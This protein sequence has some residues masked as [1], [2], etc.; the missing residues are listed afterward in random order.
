MSRKRN[1]RIHLLYPARE[2]ITQI[3]R[4]DPSKGIPEVIE[5]YRKLCD[6]IINDA[7]EKFPPQLLNCGN[8]AIDDPDAGL[9]FAETTKLLKQS[10]Y[11][12]IARDVVAQ[13]SLRDGFELKVSKALYHRKSVVAT[14]A[15]DSVA[16]Y[17]F[18]LY[19]DNDL[20]TQMSK[21]TKARV[22]D[23]V[24]TVGNAGCWLYLTAKLARGGDL[25]PQ[26]QWIMDMLMVAAGQKYEIGQPIF[27]DNAFDF[28][29]LACNGGYVVSNSVLVHSNTDFFYYFKV[30]TTDKGGLDEAICTIRTA[31]STRVAC[32]FIHTPNVKQILQ[33][34]VM[35]SMLL[36]TKAKGGLL[37]LHSS[38]HS[39]E[40]LNYPIV[41]SNLEVHLPVI[42]LS[43]N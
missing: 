3:A 19:P 1:L 30:D 41:E 21:H 24:G 14:R 31:S 32:D 43:Y 28:K 42:P 39:Y 22:S 35:V 16:N 20:Y 27:P 7:P 13:L 5:S 38:S 6:R 36:E 25:Q 8:G 29:V 15:G 11:A 40:S 33:G 26:D 34:L 9:V 2:Y 18:D 37:F 17:L 10:T 23:E 12:G 4:F